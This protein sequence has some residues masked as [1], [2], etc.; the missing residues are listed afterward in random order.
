MK[1]LIWINKIQRFDFSSKIKFI[2]TQNAVPLQ[3]ETIILSIKIF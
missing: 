3:C 1:R 2:L